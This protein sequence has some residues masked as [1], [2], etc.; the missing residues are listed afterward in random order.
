MP[1][2]LRRTINDGPFCWLTK[3]AL[4]K[5]REAFDAQNAVPSAIA[6]Y[7]A[8]AELASDAQR[9]DFARDKA[10]I[11]QRAGLGCRRV[12]EI[13]QDLQAIGLVDIQR[14]KLAGTSINGPNV[15]C[16][17]A[18][19]KAAGTCYQP[20]GT[21]LPQSI[22]VP[23]ANKAPLES[24]GELAEVPKGRP[25][26]AQRF[27]VGSVAGK[28]IRPEGTAEIRMQNDRSADSQ[29][30]LRDEES[31]AE[32]KPDVETLGYFQM[33]LR[34][35]SQGTKSV[36]NAASASVSILPPP[37]NGCS[38]P[39]NGC[40]IPGSGGS[41]RTADSVEESEE[42]T[43]D[44]GAFES[45]YDAYPRKVG[46]QPA[47]KAIRVAL[48][49][50]SFEA[51]LAKTKAYAA[52]RQGQDPQYTPHPATWFSQRRWADEIE[53]RTPPPRAIPATKRLEAVQRLIRNHPAN[54]ESENYRMN[55]KPELVAELA[56]LR[57]KEDAIYL[58]I[59]Q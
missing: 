8:L 48:K 50:I 13:L 1:D 29:P 46:K 28:D 36:H 16:L 53:A 6:V 26:I 32:P 25:T 33:S 30:S 17:K 4:W 56:A 37:G 51:L 38:I 24:R 44:A 12:Q 57:I 31:I 40:S 58:E 19:Q 20:P 42:S 47:L 55:P 39:G 14:Q 10:T 22:G 15:Y 3:A 45:I 11:A 5:I 23:D 7:V 9:E 43:S 41:I 27:N 59:A 18:L 21:G 35:N 34:D 52:S 49:T 54:H 2:N